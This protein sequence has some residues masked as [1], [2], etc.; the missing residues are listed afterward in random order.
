MNHI[1]KITFLF[2]ILVLVI[3]VSTSVSSA[4]NQNEYHYFVRAIETEE[5][6]IDHPA[7]LAFSPAAN[8]FFVARKGSAQGPPSPVN[9]LTEIT[10]FEDF[11]GSSTLSDSIPDPTNLAFDQK[12]NS[13]FFVDTG[14]QELVQVPAG[15]DGLLP[16][17]AQASARYNF[18]A[19]GIQN[20]KGIA[21]DSLNRRLFFL[22]PAG[23]R[24][25]AVTE[26][27]E[28]GFNGE[29]IYQRG[30]YVLIDLKTVS[31]DK[32]QGLG[33]NS[34]DAH[35]YVMNPKTKEVLEFTDTGDHV[36][37]HN[38]SDNS[39][40][41]PQAMLFAA[42]GDP[43][44]DPAIMNLF[45]AD[46]G[47][48][49]DGQTYAQILEFSFTEPEIT[50]EVPAAVS[51]SLVNTID[52]SKWNPPSPD[53]TGLDYWESHGNFLLSDSEVDEMSIFEGKNV[54]EFRTNGNLV[55]TCVTLDFSKEAP[56]L[57]INPGNNHI[58]F[59]DDGKD[60]IF[61]I[62]LGAD[63]DYCTNDDEVRSVRNSD[64]GVV[65][66]E[67]LAFGNGDLYIADGLS[68]EIYRIRPG[69]NGIFDGAPPAG[70]DNV[71]HFDT[72][73]MGLRDPEGIGFS[74]ASGTLFIVSRPDKKLLVE[75]STTGNVINTFDIGF[76]NAV[77]PSGVGIGPG[78]N[79][80]SQMNIYMSARGVDN[81]S[82]PKENDGKVYEISIGTISPT[83]TEPTPTEPTPTEPTPTEPTPPP[84][85]NAL[86]LSLVANGTVNGLSV[87]DEDII[88]FNGSSFSMFFDGSDVGVGGLDITAFA[89]TGPNTIL[90]SFSSSATISGVGAVSPSDIVQ[91]N[92]ASLGDNTNGSFSMYMNGIDVGLDASAEAI[93]AFD[94]LPDGRIVISTKGNISVPGFSGKDEDLAALSPT[95]LGDNTS[96]SWEIYFD[97]S[98]V[99]LA[100]NSGEDIDG[101]SIDTSGNLYFSTRNVFSV[102]GVSGDN[103]DVFICQPTSLGNTTACS[104]LP[105]LYFDG[106]QW[107]LAGN[108]I[109]GVDIP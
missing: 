30:R 53:P 91:F 33:Y 94:I 84:G 15:P 38:L 48:N 25:L 79:N 37:T 40:R 80:S 109:D 55:S 22:D 87:R 47:E 60:R 39:I 93:D 26:D 102:S 2:I 54:F 66:S 65:D 105:A 88:L 27:P 59:A 101:L 67:G 56:G 95:S 52:T 35:L 96:G 23:K 73:S 19:F 92:A 1:N 10:M 103:E 13:L 11:I 36:S 61:E 31:N 78:S 106:S 57:A 75:V 77:A 70:D 14:S 58:F 82:D 49:S 85:D 100:T 107:G 108:D 68:A 90:M 8:A 32:F 62:D 29:V 83:P 74:P 63:G 41:D 42:S 7:G 98:D 6:G 104:Y 18:K 97:G 76:L 51:P 9:D 21:F 28:A 69:S 34:N 64:Y 81:N 89:V 4:Q 99:D 72:N 12:T 20:S 3:A 24:V 46:S 16:P 44:D 86:Y 45:I 43:T 17:A 71:S 5:L 50:Q